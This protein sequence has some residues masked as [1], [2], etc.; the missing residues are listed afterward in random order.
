MKQTG[1]KPKW[2]IKVAWN[3]S[4]CTCTPLDLTYIQVRRQS[5]KWQTGMLLNRTVIPWGTAQERSFTQ[6]RVKKIIWKSVWK[7][8]VP[9]AKNS[10]ATPFPPVK[11][12]RLFRGN[13][14]VVSLDQSFFLNWSLSISAVLRQAQNIV[15]CNCQI[16]KGNFKERNMVF[17]WAFSAQK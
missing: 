14:R 9:H 5:F 10:S 1:N 4:V 16:F 12:C 6:A 3:K 15:F 7:D 11:L 8:W 13:F 2:Q 17:C